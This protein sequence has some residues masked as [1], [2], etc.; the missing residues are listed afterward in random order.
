MGHREWQAA[1]EVW[2]GLGDVDAR[3]AHCLAAVLASLRR[4]EYVKWTLRHPV[5]DLAAG[6]EPFVVAWTFDGDRIECEKT[7]SAVLI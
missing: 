3:W 7:H 6:P 4:R 5:L 1:V 2:E